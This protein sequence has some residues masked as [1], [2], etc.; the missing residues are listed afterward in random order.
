MTRRALILATLVATLVVALHASPSHGQT[1]VDQR[2]VPAVQAAKGLPRLH[3]LVVSQRGQVLMEYYARGYSAGRVANIKS[4][5]KSIIS[6]LVGIAV[7]RKLI[8][9]VRSPIAR[10]FPALAQDKDPRKAQITIDDLLTMRAGLDTTSNRNYGAW[11]TSP[12]WVR[13]VLTRQLVAVPGSTMQ[14]STGS[15]HL[16]SAILSSASKSTTWQFAQSALARPLGFT[17][18]QW[19]RDPQG[20]YFGGND[21]LLTPR[22]MLAF[23][24]LFLHDGRVHGQQVVPETWV[25]ESCVPKTTSRFDAGREYGYGWWIDEVGGQPACYAWGY[26]GQYIFV[27]RNLDAVIVATSSTSTD[28]ERRGYR[29]QLLALIAERIVAALE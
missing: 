23:G 17:L 24:E 22:Q 14:Y 27:L 11:V 16:L 13:F 21:M 25:R 2:L 10:W 28:D 4:A 29:R 15:T 12:N 6:A 7:D 19:P 20:I 8:P 1:T 9:D 18:A 26:G 5:S 3:S